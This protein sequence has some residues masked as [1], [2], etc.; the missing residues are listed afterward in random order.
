MVKR[1]DEKNS[2][3]GELNYICIN[4][5]YLSNFFYF[6]PHAT[7]CFTSSS[8]ASVDTFI[9]SIE[10]RSFHLESY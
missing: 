6:L 3:E 9:Y 10:L 7:S 8:V 1:M 4:S 5:Y 2:W